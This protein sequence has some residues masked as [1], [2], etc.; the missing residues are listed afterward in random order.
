MLL[1]S[2]TAGVVGWRLSTGFAYALPVA[3]TYDGVREFTRH[4]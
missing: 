3:T 1:L 2:F 4:H